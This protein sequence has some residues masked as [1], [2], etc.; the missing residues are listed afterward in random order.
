MSPR[1]KAH[2]ADYAAFHATPGNQACHYVGIP[3]IVLT[4]FTFLTSAPLLDVA[5]FG[6]TLA[7]VVLAA[8]VL[9]YFSLDAALASLMLVLLAVLDGLGRQLP[10]RAAAALFVLGWA[11]Q[12]AGHYVY[13]RKAPAFF[14]NLAHLLVGPLWIAAK[15]VGRA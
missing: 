10:L 6:V 8:V 1:L 4:L 5:G 3:L 2:F 9:Y 13:E 12:F 15:A 7:E 11:L 14:R